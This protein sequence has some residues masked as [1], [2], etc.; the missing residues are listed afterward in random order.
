MR[1]IGFRVRLL[2]AMLSMMLV[3]Q[4]ASSYVVLE[5]TRHEGEERALAELEAGA[6]IFERLLL[7]RERQLLSNVGLLVRDFGLRR[8]VATGDAATV[9][10]ALENHGRR[11]GASLSFLLDEAGGLRALDPPDA[12]LESERESFAALV[13]TAR[14]DGGAS[15]IAFVAGHPQQLVLV[16]VEAP[17]TI[18]WIG[19]GFELD[20]RLAKELQ[21][22]TGLHVSFWSRPD[23]ERSPA[24][25]STLT[26]RDERALAGRIE[27]GALEATGPDFEAFARTGWITRPVTFDGRGDEGFG[28][29]LQSSYAEAMAPVTAQRRELG[30][31]FA[32]AIAVALAVALAIARRTTRPIVRLARVARAISDGNL[33][34]TIDVPAAHD[35]FGELARSFRVM[36]EA[37]AERE[38]RILHE[39]RHDR[40][41]GLPN[42]HA[43]E[44][45]LSERIA[46]GGEFA[47]VIFDIVRL[48]D[49]N[50]AFGAQVGDALLVDTAEALVASAELDWVGRLGGDEFLAIFAEGH[51]GGIEA[52]LSR[53]LE[54]LERPREIGAVRVGV[55]LVAGVAL[56]PQDGADAETLMRRGEMALALAKARGARHATYVAGLEEAHHRRVGLAI[57][58]ERA[59]ETGQLTLHYQPKVALESARVVGAESLIRWFHPEMGR[60]NPEEFIRV[61]EQTGSIG[62][63]SDWVL[64]AAV[65]QIA[66]WAGRDIAL[67]VS[68]NL[69]ATDVADD[70]LPDRVAEALREARVAASRLRI[71]VTE[72]AVMDRP[73]HAAAVLERIRALGVGVS[74]DDFGTGHAS[75]AQLR[76]LPVDELKIDQSFVRQLR[77]GTADEAIVRTTIELGH[78]LGLEVVA[79][80]VEDRIAWDVL[81][82]C[83]CDVAQGYWMGKP[84]PASEFVEWLDRFEKEGPDDSV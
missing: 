61:A 81:S 27:A 77:A 51:A 32:A 7:D 76:T 22:L 31:F 83:G 20:V 48:K 6:R 49:I 50:G 54:R 82:R 26:P 63:V 53:T 80:G 73:E 18:G 3:L 4:G 78:S 28:A 1:G 41:T 15:G 59:L 2:L 11:V 45:A 30:T 58:L 36:Q 23:P 40:L 21:E 5:R 69:S 57:E 47:V 75:L 42:R 70:D 37:V 74:L 71:E 34:A 39:S 56:A 24:L 55:S 52:G 72:S 16:P 68:I 9:A 29:V 33:G 79:E 38:A 84:M 14:A 8:A 25:S 13:E 44:R 10:S 66:E 60:M 64:G 12:R 67:T 43:I 62:R 65:R 19:M 17:R 35:E 46:R